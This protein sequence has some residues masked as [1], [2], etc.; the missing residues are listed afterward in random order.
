MED[1]IKGRFTMSSGVD[2]L[3]GISGLLYRHLSAILLYLP[4][5]RF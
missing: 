3:N 2:V 1:I 5:Q 4:F